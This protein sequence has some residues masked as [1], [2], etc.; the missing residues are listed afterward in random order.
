[1]PTQDQFNKIYSSVLLAVWIISWAIN[2]PISIE[3]TVSLAGPLIAHFL[4]LGSNK[5]SDKAGS[6]ERT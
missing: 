1:M 6:N 5:L 2:K 4:H 3:Q